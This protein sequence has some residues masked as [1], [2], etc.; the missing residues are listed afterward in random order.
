ML[1]LKAFQ[2]ESKDRPDNDRLLPS[3]FASAVVLGFT[4]KDE[5]CTRR[6]GLDLDQLSEEEQIEVEDD[7]R[8]CVKRGSEE[9]ERKNQRPQEEKPMIEPW[10]LRN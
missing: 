8:I 4:S 5:P 6:A 7:Y 3:G 10:V 1:S 2:C 9:D